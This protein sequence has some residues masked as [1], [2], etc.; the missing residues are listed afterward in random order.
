MTT[1]QQT[2]EE[3]EQALRQ[4]IK[5]VMQTTRE[6]IAEHPTLAGQIEFNMLKPIAPSAVKLNKENAKILYFPTHKSEVPH[7]HR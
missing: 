4:W 5:E 1:P 2:P 6:I 7:D 3:K